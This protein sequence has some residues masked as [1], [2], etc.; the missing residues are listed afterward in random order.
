MTEIFIV[1]DGDYSEYRIQGVFTDPKD[2]ERFR[3]FHNYDQVEVHAVNPEVPQYEALRFRCYYYMVSDA[4]HIY[5]TTN[6]GEVDDKIN[7]ND[8]GFWDRKKQ[9]CLMG[10]VCAKTE[11]QARKVWQD[12]L[13]AARA[14]SLFVYKSVWRSNPKDAG[15]VRQTLRW[16]G[17]V[18]TTLICEDR[19]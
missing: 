4:S 13:N 17:G 9:P 1:T 16:N 10:V 15:L 14:G 8:V 19:I 12:K 7:L 5:R 18:D 6:D 3:E 11:E 2:A